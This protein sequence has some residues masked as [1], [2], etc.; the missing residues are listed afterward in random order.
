MIDSGTLKAGDKLPLTREL[1][2][3]YGVTGETVRQAIIKLKASGLVWSMQGSGVY[4]R[5]WKPM[6]YRPQE[7]FRRQPLTREM[8]QFMTQMRDE[9]R[10]SSQTIEVE[11]VDPDPEVQKRL[12]LRKGQKVV[13]RRRTRSVDGQLFNINDS[14]FPLS[15]VKGSVIM[16][17]D[18]IPRGA[19]QILTDLGHEQVRALDEIYIR[20]PTPEQATRLE[21][22]PGTPVAVHLATGYAADG[23]PVRTVV[24]V[25]PGD[26]HVITYERA[27]PPARREL[28]IRR[29]AAADLGVVTSLWQEAAA[30]LAD[31]G[32]DQWQ[33]PPREEKIVANIDRGEC[34]LIEDDGVP[35][36]T[37]TVD[38]FADP[39]FWTPD[40][41]AEPALYVH[42]MAVRRDAA[43]IELGSAM[44]DWASLQAHQQGRRWVRLDAWRDNTDLISYYSS[45]D[46]QHVRT[47][48]AEGRGS[49]ALFQRPAGRTRGAGPA[50]KER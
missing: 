33:Y 26:R 49:G 14:Y 43:G 27:K 46:F 47:V 29:A 16:S 48:N 32:V 31:K 7:E 30:W 15:L 1:I 2:Q 36:A 20:M 17:A 35:V 22:G 28:D 39:D 21:L 41:A 4:V 5:E 42:R 34:F 45:R 18:D 10:A 11:V 13:V 40:E 3:R 25:L 24:N 19:N 9:G 37:I 38:T 23:R 50:L 12:Q 6:A 44:L 8:D